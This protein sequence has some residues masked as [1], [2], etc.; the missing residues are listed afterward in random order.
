MVMETPSP[1]CVGREFVRQ[2][3]TL[4]HEA[5]LHLHR[6]YSHNSSFVHG[7]VEKPGEEQPPVMGQADIHKKIMSLNFCDCHAKIRQVDSQATVGNAVVVQ[8]TGELSNNGMQMR[9]FMQTFVLAPQS[10]K[11][12]YVHNDI[13]RY[14]DEVFHDNDTDTENQEDAQDSEGEI[15]EPVGVQQDLLADTQQF[16]DAHAPSLSNGTGMLEEEQIET[17][18]SPKSEP[19]EPLEPEEQIPA[20][21]ETYEPV[22]EEPKVE[23]A[24]PEEPPQVDEPRKPFSWA[25]LASKGT[26]RPV[27]QQIPSQPQQ[28]SMKSSGFGTR[29]EV[30]QDTSPT[31]PK[32]QRAPRGGRD[33]PDRGRDRDRVSVT[34]E[35]GENMSDRRGARYPDSHQLFVGNLPHNVAEQ[36][37]RKF[38][39]SYGNVMELRINTKG[40]SGSKI[41]NFGFVVFDNPDPVQNILQSKPIKFHDHR[42][43]V[44]EKKP[45]GSEGRP[46]GRGPPPRS[47]SAGGGGGGY[48][49]RGGSAGR[50]MGPRGGGGPP[51]MRDGGRGGGGGMGQRGGMSGPRR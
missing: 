48:G 21:I 33:R 42:L 2:Y 15:V 43:N 51:G 29:Q 5:P 32:E 6:F 36:E 45:R 35:D 17:P 49:N 12:Y 37:L 31:A 9:R 41:P 11:K 30:K 34:R 46:M 7:G 26:S 13:F 18:T 38:F 14:Q 4:L 8:V 47:G 50:G 3:Y 16:F 27:S 24:Q 20:Q 10:P 39:E 22:K 19:E 1:Q 40:G 23:P 25:D 44:E 28:Q